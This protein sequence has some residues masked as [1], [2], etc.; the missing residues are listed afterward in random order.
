MKNNWE[1]ISFFQVSQGKVFIVIVLNIARH[2]TWLYL[3][4]FFFKKQNYFCHVSASF[5]FILWTGVFCAFY[6]SFWFWRFLNIFRLE[7]VHG[8]TILACFQDFLNIDMKL[9]QESFTPV[10]QA[11]VTFWL[12]LRKK[13][14]VPKLSPG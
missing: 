7:V 10:H 5:Y 2:L 9:S 3:S 13:N 14:G 12:L 1:Y 11:Q 8:R 4:C 6:T